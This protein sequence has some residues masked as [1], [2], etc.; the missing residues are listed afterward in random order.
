MANLSVRKIDDDIYE[1]LRVQAA[2]H[3]ISMEE[4]VRRILKRAVSA[5]DRLGELA[6]ECF[7]P[8]HSVELELPPWKPHEPLD[9]GE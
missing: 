7:G 8:A 6:L 4:E 3:G 1:R 2:E 5:P 9:L